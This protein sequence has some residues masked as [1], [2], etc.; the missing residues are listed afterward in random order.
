MA[1]TAAGVY[2]L[3][4]A[5]TGNLIGDYTEEIAAHQDVREGMQED[6]P[7]LWATVALVRVAP[8]G[9]RVPIAQGADLLTRVEAKAGMLLTNNPRRPS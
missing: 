5:E 6:G 1:V 2:E 3:W 4:D 8:D 9:M 7:D